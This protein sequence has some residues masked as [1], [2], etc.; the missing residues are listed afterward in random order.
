MSRKQVAASGE[1]ALIEKPAYGLIAKP[2]GG[3]LGAALAAG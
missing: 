3:A 1:R 2:D